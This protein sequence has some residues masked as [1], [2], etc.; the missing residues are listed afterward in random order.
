MNWYRENRWLGNFLIGFGLALLVGLWFLF[1]AKGAFADA[2]T[3]FNAAATERS[4][5][6]HLNPF[7]NE[8]NFKKTQA[9]FENYGASLN[10]IKEELKAQVLPASPMQPNEFQTHLRQAIVNVTEKARPNRVKLPENFHL[11]F[12]EFVN[13]LPGTTE[14][15]LLGEELQQLEL[16]IGILID[17]KVDSITALKRVVS[18]P[19]T[20]PAAPSPP[21]KTATAGPTVVERVTVD[22]TFAASPSSLRKTLNQIAASERQFFVVRTFYVHNEQAKAPSREQS[23]A[24][25]AT[26]TTAPNALKFIVGSEHVDTTLT[27]E[28]V[29]FAF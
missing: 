7:P 1:H 15:P 25:A 8:E 27:V 29:R 16:L 24:S 26:A 14:A 6:E 28:L 12:D 20:A 13:A 11:G 10:K 18:P 9:A 5:L 4:R 19:A 21:P 2:M 22:L 23:A 17:A 3:E